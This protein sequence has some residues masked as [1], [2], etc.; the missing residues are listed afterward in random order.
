LV[1]KAEGQ[2]VD[3]VAVMT[4][5]KPQQTGLSLTTSKKTGQSA[6][7]SRDGK[8]TFEKF[9]EAAFEEIINTSPSD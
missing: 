7:V 1:A 8:V 4:Q 3:D 5:W 2:Q 6:W 9:G